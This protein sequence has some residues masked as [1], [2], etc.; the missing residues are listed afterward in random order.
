MRECNTK[1]V[2]E[3]DEEFLRKF[4]EFSLDSWDHRTHLRIA[5]V[6]LKLKGF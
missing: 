3:P 1:V 4:Q 2:D 5:W 6:Y